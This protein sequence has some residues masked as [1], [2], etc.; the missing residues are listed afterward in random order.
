MIVARWA[1]LSISQSAQLLGFHAQPI[2][3]FKKKN[4]L[5]R[6]KD[7]VLPE[8]TMTQLTISSVNTAWCLHRLNSFF[9]G[10]CIA[11]S[12]NKPKHMSIVF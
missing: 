4:G 1:G 9:C 3:R 5:Q 7:S 6:I 10:H 8:I 2:L 11:T 12:T